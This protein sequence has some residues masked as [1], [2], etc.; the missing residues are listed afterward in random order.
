MSSFELLSVEFGVVKGKYRLFTIEV[1]E[2]KVW[3]FSKKEKF[4]CFSVVLSSGIML[5][6]SFCKNGATVDSLFQGFSYQIENL[7][8][9]HLFNE[10]T[11]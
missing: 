3:W 9:L 11:K 8:T 2:T 7:Y 1:E 6:P 5:T 10:A 4:D